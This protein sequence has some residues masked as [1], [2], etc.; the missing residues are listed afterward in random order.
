MT[1]NQLTYK[2]FMDAA[3]N[4]KGFLGLQCNDCGAYTFPPQGVCRECGSFNYE[5][6]QLSGR[7]IIRSYTVIRVPP[8]GFDAGYIVGLVELFEGPWVMVNIRTAEQPDMNLIGKAGS[9]ICNETREDKFSGGKK[10]VFL[11]YPD[12]ESR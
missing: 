1:L 6:V 12:S 4:D 5:V 3:E 2:M 10:I 11:F 9:V 8:E 7:G